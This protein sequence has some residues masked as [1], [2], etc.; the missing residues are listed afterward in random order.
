MS[1]VWKQCP[2]ITG[3]ISFRDELGDPFKEV[4]PIVIVPE[5]LLFFDPPYDHMMHNTGSI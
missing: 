2:S 1:V 4:L 5:Y 3:G